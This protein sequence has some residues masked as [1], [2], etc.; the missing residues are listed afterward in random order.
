MGKNGRSGRV[1]LLS[2]WT[3][4]ILIGIWNA[5][6]WDGFSRG[7]Q[8]AGRSAGRSH[9]GSIGNTTNTSLKSN[10][11]EPLVN[12]G[13]LL[14]STFPSLQPS[15][16]SKSVTPCTWNHCMDISPT[17]VV[18][19][20][21]LKAVYYRFM[22]AIDAQRKILKNP[23]A[24]ERLGKVGI[25]EVCRQLL[26]WALAKTNKHKQIWRAHLQSLPRVHWR[27]NNCLHEVWPVK[28]LKKWDKMSVSDLPHIYLFM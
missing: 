20:N 17:E 12:Y 14:S 4:L 9:N 5:R 13:Q 8:Q 11:W 28:W 16:L 24:S 1:Q 10:Q 26:G 22:M 3:K 25:P 15:Q 21:W 7:L 2:G 19:F 6:W 23:T 27:K 18:K